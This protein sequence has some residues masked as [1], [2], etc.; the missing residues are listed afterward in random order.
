[1]NFSLNL[2][3]PP[4]KILIIKPSAFGDIVHALPVLNMLHAG[5]PAAKI[6]WVVARGLHEILEDHPMIEKLW[7]I[8]KNSWKNL[9]NLAATLTELR[10][11]AS[12][13]RKEEFDLVIDLQGLFRSAMIGLF[14]GSRERVGFG[15]AREGAKYTYKYRIRTN[16]DEH[17]VKRNILIPLALGCRMSDFAFP[18][19]SFD[20]RDRISKRLPPVYAVIAPSAGTLVKRWPAANFGAVASRLPFPSVVVGGASDRSLAEEVSAAS[21]G[22]AFSLAGE[23]SL[24]ELAAVIKG[25]RFLLSPDTGP[26][27][28]AAALNVPTFVIFGPTNPARTGPYGD[29]HTIIRNEMDCS[30]C[31][32]RKP[33]ADWRCMREITPERVNETIDASPHIRCKE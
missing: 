4:R 11:L 19:P 10:T 12:A 2:T 6:H 5:F 16:W 18:F 28:I 33:C 31:Y 30:P 20:L 22:R 14:T 27:H 29:C 17:A 21:R 32:K 9:S 25:S 23:L 3:R 1:M 24:R 13:L 7:I 26:M 15:I 8:D